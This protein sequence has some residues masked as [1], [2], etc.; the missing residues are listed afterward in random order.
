[1]GKKKPSPTPPTNN[2][3]QYRE[4]LGLSK[5]DLA[6]LAE[7]SDKTIARI[8]KKKEVFRSITYRRIFNALNKVR[9]KEGLSELDFEQL[10]PK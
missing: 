3:H 8:E 9:R 2:L 6:R 7:L 10:F 1:M 5:V 4:E